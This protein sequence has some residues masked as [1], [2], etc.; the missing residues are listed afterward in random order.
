MKH[1]ISLVHIMLFTLFFSKSTGTNSKQHSVE[2]E[3]FQKGYV[4]DAIRFDAKTSTCRKLHVK[5]IHLKLS[6]FD[7]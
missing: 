3:A 2:E 7:A 6:T 4:V 5:Y 1:T